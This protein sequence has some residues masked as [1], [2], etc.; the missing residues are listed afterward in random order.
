[1]DDLKSLLAKKQRECKEA[2]N[3]V[4]ERQR[5]CKVL[6]EALGYFEINRGIKRQL[7][8]DSDSSEY[9]IEEIGNPSYA[10]ASMPD[11]T[12]VGPVTRTKKRA[13]E[14]T[15]P[16]INAENVHS[17][18]YEKEEERASVNTPDDIITGPVTRNK[19]KEVQAVTE[20]EDGIGTICS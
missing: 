2:Q 8:F 18:Y 6:R 17:D 4:T 16:I 1:M 3:V 12:I 5:E 7:D 10:S 19:K 15:S 9:D 14:P 11:G 20:N 13:V